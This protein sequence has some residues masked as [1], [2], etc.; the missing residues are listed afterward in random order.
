MDKYNIFFIFIISYLIWKFL[1]FNVIKYY[2]RVAE[3]VWRAERGGWWLSN[4]GKKKR[5]TYSDD[6]AEVFG[7]EVDGEFD[8]VLCDHFL[9]TENGEEARVMRRRKAREEGA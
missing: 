6:F 5:V 3:R 2:R 8:A 4:G 7:D 9:L 1:F